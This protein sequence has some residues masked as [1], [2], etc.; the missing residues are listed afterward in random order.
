MMGRKERFFT[1]TIV[2]WAED[3]N[4]RKFPWRE[5]SSVWLVALAEILLVR[6]PAVRVLPVYLNLV[7]KY[8]SPFCVS[9]DDLKELECTLKPLGLQS[10]KAYQIKVLSEVLRG[11]EKRAVV[12]ELKKVPG[13][14]TY[15]YNAIL[16]FAL[17]MVRPVVDG[18]IGRIF[19]RYF[20]VKWKG[21]AVSDGNAWS[22]ASVLV[23]KDAGTAK[24]YSYGLID[25][26]STVCKKKPN[27]TVCPL[28]ERCKFFSKK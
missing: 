18:N 26:G 16:L 12:D 4:L 24:V 23:P 20:G 17:S 10:K 28:K 6:T 11:K 14:G 15:A 22:L 25:F 2:K 13:I 19:S 9:D 8:P 1:E 3:G 21:K 27:C 5:T 7:E